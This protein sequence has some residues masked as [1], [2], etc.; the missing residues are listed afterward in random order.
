MR[1]RDKSAGLVRFVRDNLRQIIYDALE[2]FEKLY[3]SAFY[4]KY[5]A[6][7]ATVTTTTTAFRFVWRT[8]APPPIAFHP[9]GTKK[10][11]GIKG[12]RRAN[13]DLGRDAL[14][15]AGMHDRHTVIENPSSRILGIEKSHP[16]SFGGKGRH[17]AKE[18][19]RVTVG[20]DLRLA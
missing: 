14:Y 19:K 5:G 2:H 9:R 16:L 3:A 10:R 6:R 20:V 11:M 17:A 4:R 8:E 15:M 12:K 7:I 1:P 13:L 18:K